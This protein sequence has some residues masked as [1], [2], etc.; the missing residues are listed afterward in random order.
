MELA[1][2]YPIVMSRSRRMCFFSAVNI[3]GNLSK[4]SK[5]VTWKWDP[6]IPK[7]QQIM[8]ECYGSAPKFSPNWSVS[9]GNPGPPIIA[10]G[11][12]WDVG[13]GGTLSGYRLTDGKLMFSSHTAPVDTD[14]P[15]LSASGSRL[16]VPEGD[17]VVSYL[18]I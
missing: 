14:F 4:K 5:R 1:R 17:Q 7:A 12:V 11:V 6:R 8:N 15:S 18:G 13:R 3:D 2:G 9:G 10:G 16:I